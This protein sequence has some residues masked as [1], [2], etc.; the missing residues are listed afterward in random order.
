M[1]ITIF[2]HLKNITIQK[3]NFLGEENW[4]NW[5][6]NRFL[7]MDPDYCEVVNFVQKNTFQMTPEHLYNL[8]RDLIPKRYIF[9]KYIK[10]QSKKEYP[11]EDILSISSYFEISQREAK[12]YYN[13]LSKDE[14]E[15]IKFQING[16]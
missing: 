1:A 3:G 11:E 10:N 8:Y 6:I 14:I 4:S 16:K 13:L 7:S 15:N 12:D 5:M 9:L 2:D